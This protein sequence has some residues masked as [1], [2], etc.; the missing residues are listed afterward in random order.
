MARIVVVG[1]GW[2]GVSAALC[3]SNFDV[4]VVLLEKTDRLLGTGLVG[5][6]MRNNGRYTAAEELIALG[7]GQLIE[8]CDENAVHKDISF[9]GHR[10]ATL[11]NVIKVAQGINGILMKKNISIMFKSRAVDVNMEGNR[12]K[13]LVLDSGDYIEGDVFVD[14]T[15]TGGPMANCRRHG[16][17]CVMCILRCPTFGG[18]SSITA[19]TGIE[20]TMVRNK[21]NSIGAMSG[22][23][24]LVPETI[25]PKLLDELK[26][27]GYVKIPLPVQSGLINLNKKVCQQYA[28]EEYSTNLI[29]LDTGYVKMMASY[30][31]LNVLNSL[32]GLERAEYKDPYSGGIGNSVRFAERCS[33]DKNLKVKGI[34]N[35]YVAGEKAASLVGHTEAMATGTLAGYN[36]VRHVNDVEPLALPPSLAL[37]DIISYGIYLQDSN[38][39]DGTKLTFSGS[40]YFEKMQERGL[41]TR[42][43]DLIKGRVA[44]TGLENI[45]TYL[46]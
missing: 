8:F 20:E 43:I 13:G 45:F 17:G 40:V 18:R 37:G 15:G 2:G 46:P 1:G 22:A 14:A 5:G 3:A 29:L 19:K 33:I 42:D 12:L 28:R 34:E 31:P 23:C 9:P 24:E 39:K 10:H 27:K 36:C 38:R 41:Y 35:L 11:Y 7:G 6:I 30:L 32:P 44:R 21:D 16:H 4:E 25:H 26:E